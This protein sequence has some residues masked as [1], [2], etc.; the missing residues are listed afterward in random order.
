MAII[1]PSL[2]FEG[3]DLGIQLNPEPGD[4]TARLHEVRYTPREKIIF[5]LEWSLVSPPANFPYRPVSKTYTKRGINLLYQDTYCWKR[6]LKCDMGA[7]FDETVEIVRSWIDEEANVNVAILNPDKG[8][9]R[10][11]TRIWSL[12][13]NWPPPWGQAEED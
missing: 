7:T 11:V 5:W 2:V 12:G 8:P 10:V 9:L 3:S 13:M 4:Y 6:K 1:Q